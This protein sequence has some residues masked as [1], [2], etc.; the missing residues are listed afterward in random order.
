MQS[1]VLGQ[2]V[3]CNDKY[4][5]CQSG[6]FDDFEFVNCKLKTDDANN[7]VMFLAYQINNTDNE[8]SS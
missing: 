2:G 7:T 6:I 1:V 4:V 3:I 8:S 5:T